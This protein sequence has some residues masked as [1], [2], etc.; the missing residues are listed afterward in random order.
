[1]VDWNL[2][3]SRYWGTPLPIWKN[4][5]H[6]LEV[7]IGSVEELK[8]KGYLFN[9]QKFVEDYKNPAT[10]L[11]FK[12]TNFY[13]NHPDLHKRNTDYSKIFSTSLQHLYILVSI[14]I[15]FDIIKEY[16]S[17]LSEIADL[18]LHKPYVDDF[19]LI[20]GD[21]ILT[22]VPDLVDVWFD[23][24]AMPYAQWHFPFENKEI[25]AQNFPADFIAEGVDQTRG[26]FYTLHA[27]GVLLFDSVAYKTVVSNGLV[28]DKNGNKMSKRLGNVI[29]PFETINKYG[30][31]ATRWYLITNA[32][33]WDSLKFDIEGIKEIQR[34]FFGT[35]Y[36]T[37]QFF[38][39][40][41]N[42]DGFAFKE[43]YIPVKERPEI[44]QWVLSCLNTLIK[45][46]QQSLDEYEPTQAGRAIEEFVDAHL[47]NWYVRLCRRRFWKGEYEQDKICA[48]QTLYECLQTISQLIAP[49]APF[50]ADWLFNNLNAVS[51]KFKENSV[52]HTNFPKTNEET[53]DKALEERMQLAQDICSLALSIRKKVKIKVRQPLEQLLIP[54]DLKFFIPI[55]KVEEL[56]KS[57]INV[58]TIKV[59]DPLQTEFKM[60]LEP[61]F[62]L[63]GKKL[64]KRMKIV[65][66]WADTMNLS[67]DKTYQ[68][69][70]SLL[71]NDNE[72]AKIYIKNE[73]PQMHLVWHN[74]NFLPNLQ[75]KNM[76]IL[77]K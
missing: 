77:S 72:V 32:S 38:A 42:V 4:G 16:L 28:L 27:L 68:T 20:E 29:D 53:I 67:N 58:K 59:V 47:S 18:D 48:Y 7:C 52:H 69:Q 51:N 8:Q 49:I 12:I 11:A 3:R 70:I 37:Y 14:D 66:K 64:G 17:P 35:L 65:K 61:K 43:K 50:F 62:E 10:N 56:I 1:M 33:P 5:V 75:M 76:M 73:E 26:W 63:L 34:K 57:E 19:I 6:N 15:R 36:N 13:D 39:L 25:F 60:K 30:A 74:S 46:V 23:S 44:D 54:I 24:G 22:I 71:N 41:A 40:Y 9:K 21:K 45:S 31:D 55:K 2:S